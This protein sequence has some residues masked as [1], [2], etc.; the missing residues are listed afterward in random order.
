MVVKYIF[1]L[2]FNIFGPPFRNYLYAFSVMKMNI[3]PSIEASQFHIAFRVN[4]QSDL[5]LIC[6]WSQKFRFFCSELVLR[7][8]EKRWVAPVEFITLQQRAPLS[9][10]RDS[11][12]ACDGT[13][14]C[15]CVI[16]I[17]SN[18]IQSD[19]RVLVTC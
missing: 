3:S 1:S 11:M 7:L 6:D 19:F 16:K 8:S 18:R 17:H 9:E 12:P 5:T 15:W 13:R 14:I 2:F 10:E 4:S